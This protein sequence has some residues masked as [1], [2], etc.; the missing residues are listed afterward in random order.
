MWCIYKLFFNWILFHAYGVNKYMHLPAI[1]WNNLYKHR[2]GFFFLIASC[3]KFYARTHYYL[4]NWLWAPLKSTQFFLWV[5]ANVQNNCFIVNT[6]W[7]RD[8]SNRTKKKINP[9]WWLILTNMMSINL[10]ARCER[11]QKQTL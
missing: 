7:W 6:L 10:C 8:A 9:K 5:L 2:N 11:E 4:Y 3:E 1:M